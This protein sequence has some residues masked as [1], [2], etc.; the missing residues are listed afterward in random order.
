MSNDE[1]KKKN[2]FSIKNPQKEAELKLSPIMR[3]RLPCWKAMMK[4]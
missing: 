1:F 2:Q 4:K 3:P